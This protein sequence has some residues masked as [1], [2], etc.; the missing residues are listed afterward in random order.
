MFILNYTGLHQVLI[1]LM[2]NHTSPGYQ[3]SLETITLVYTLSA[4]NI[5]AMQCNHS[6]FSVIIAS[7]EPVEVVAYVT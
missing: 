7:V 4:C 3:L 2:A 6:V 1:V 5:Y